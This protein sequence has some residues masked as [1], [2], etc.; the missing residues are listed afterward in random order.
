MPHS[1]VPVG[2]L[3]WSFRA[4]FLRHVVLILGKLGPELGLGGNCF[5]EIHLLVFLFL[6]L[7]VAEQ[8]RAD[9]HSDRAAQTDPQCLM[10]P[11][12]VCYSCAVHL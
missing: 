5:G 6:F 3:K 10:R 11:M 4:A 2:I 12:L 8:D 1:I 9:N 7:S